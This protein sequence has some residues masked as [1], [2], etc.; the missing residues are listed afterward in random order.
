NAFAGG[1]GN[2]VGAYVLRGVR[3]LLAEILGLTKPVP[4]APPRPLEPEVG[5]EVEGPDTEVLADLLSELGIGVQPYVTEA[6]GGS[7]STDLRLYSAAEKLQQL[8]PILE[9]DHGTHIAGLKAAT[10][11]FFPTLDNLSD[12]Q[13][14]SFTRELAS[15]KGDDTDFDAAG[16]CIAALV[17]Y[18]NILGNDIGWPVDKSVGFV[19]NRYVPKLTEGDEIR[20]A[21]IQMQLQ[22][23]FGV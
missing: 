15:H 11:Q 22:K 14:D 7:L 18:V 1:G 13:M 21:V 19:M 3:T 10:A 12:E 17:E 6:Y 5:G 8:I 4:L 20:L 2:F 23:A 16:R 9:D